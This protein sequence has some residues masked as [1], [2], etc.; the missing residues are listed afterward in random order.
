MPSVRA[1]SLAEVDTTPATTSHTMRD[2]MSSAA[3]MRPGLHRRRLLR[4]RYMWAMASAIRTTVV[5][6][7][8]VAGSWAVC[9]WVSATARACSA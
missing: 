8:A 6:V 3:T 9:V 1:R 2:T 5:T 7:I 4:A